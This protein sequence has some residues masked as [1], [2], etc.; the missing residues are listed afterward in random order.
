MGIA[1]R[2][3]A[4]RR[5]IVRQPDRRGAG[6]GFVVMAGITAP[7]IVGHMLAG[8]PDRQ[9]RSSAVVPRN[10]LSTDLMT[11]N[12]SRRGNP[13]VT[14]CWSAVDRKPEVFGSPHPRD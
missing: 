14:P 5:I 4:D 3:N 2:C 10:L 12:L 6:N 13:N 8:Q 9:F 1:S 7:G 11:A